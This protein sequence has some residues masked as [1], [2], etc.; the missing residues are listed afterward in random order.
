MRTFLVLTRENLKKGV[1][2]RW[3]E[4]VCVGDG[5]ICLPLCVGMNS[6]PLKILTFL[7]NETFDYCCMMNAL[8]I[9]RCWEGQVANFDFWALNIL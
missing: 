6:P 3:C 2:P 4:N 9:D 7:R 5:G 8:R 1:L